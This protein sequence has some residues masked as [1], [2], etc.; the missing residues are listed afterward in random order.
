MLKPVSTSIKYCDSWCT[1]FLYSSRLSILIQR[2]NP[3]S[4]LNNPKNR[5]ISN[6]NPTYLV[7]KKVTWEIKQ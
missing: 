6:Y 5:A 4:T 1:N 3:G 7:G 2:N